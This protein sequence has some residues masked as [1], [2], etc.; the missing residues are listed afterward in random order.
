MTD[1][2]LSENGSEVVAGVTPLDECHLPPA[3]LRRCDLPLMLRTHPAPIE[4]VADGV[5]ARG[6]LTL[7]A[8]R[9]KEG[10]SLLSVG[11]AACAAAG[12]GVVAGIDVRAARVLVVDAENGDAFVPLQQALGQRASHKTA[13]TSDQ[14][15]HSAA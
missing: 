12:G 6:T 8:G 11:L 3:T 13:D 14:E 9:E 4:W 1:Y 15:L 5:A 10:K 7:L 2:V